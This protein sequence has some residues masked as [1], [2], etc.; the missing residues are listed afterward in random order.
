MQL[1]LPPPENWQDFQRLCRDLWSRIWDDSNAQINGRDGLSQFGV[2]ISGFSA[3]VGFVGVQCK[4]KSLLLRTR[5]SPSELRIEV[6]RAK[7]YTPPLRQ[8]ILATTGPSDPTIQEEARRI[9]AENLRNNLFSVKVWSWTDIVLELQRHHDLLSDYFEA[10]YPKELDSPSRRTATYEAQYRKLLLA[11]VSRVQLFGLDDDPATPRDVDLR[12]AFTQLRVGFGDDGAHKRKRSFSRDEFDPGHSLSFSRM[13]GM[14]PLLG[15]RLLIEGSAGSGKTTLLHWAAAEALFFQI[16][17]GLSPVYLQDEAELTLK[18]F[19]SL[20][21][22]NQ[23]RVEFVDPSAAPG[24]SGIFRR[25]RDLFREDNPNRNSRFLIE[26]NWRRRIPFLVNLRLCTEGRLPKVDELPSHVTREVARAPEHWVAD[27][28]AD[29]RGLLLLDGIDEVPGVSRS[30]MSDSINAYLEAFG[31]STFVV[32]SRPGAVRDTVWDKLFNGMRVSVRP[33]A[34]VDRNLFIERWHAAAAKET[35]ERGRQ[36][37]AGEFLDSA[38]SLKGKIESSPALAQLSENPLLCAGICY[39]HRIRT[40]EIP[41]RI[42]SLY[43]KL[44]DMLIHRRDRERWGEKGSRAFS[45]VNAALDKEEKISILA[46]IANFMVR[47]GVFALDQKRAIRQVD[48]ALRGLRKKSISAIDVLEFL[49]ER[50]VVLSSTDQG[51]IEFINNGLRSYLAAL[52]FEAEGSETQPID[53]AIANSD[54]DLPVLAAAIGG[55]KYRKLIIEA[56]IS[57]S[58]SSS[59]K[60]ERDLNF[61]LVRCAATGLIPDELIDKVNEIEQRIL[62]PRNSEEA[63]AVAELGERIIPCLHPDG[64]MHSDVAAANVRA[65]RLMGTSESLTIVRRYLDWQSLNVVEEIAQAINPLEI[66]LVLKA[67]LVDSDAIE[68]G[69]SIRRHIVDAHLAI[70]SSR[71]STIE[72]LDLSRTGIRSTNSLTVFSRLKK[73]DLSYSMVSDLS[74]LREMNELKELNISGTDI[75]DRHSIVLPKGL[76]RF[77]AGES[78]LPL[79]ALKDI[80]QGRVWE[81]FKPKFELL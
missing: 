67:V 11:H 6:N 4:K 69:A 35:A 17:G 22:L 59:A 30:E 7:E 29:G 3:Q 42:G 78:Q 40:D 77:Y 19:R 8:F 49:E 41:R 46:T 63:A 26:K 55:T 61:M 27:T 64:R 28:L 47:E 32:T 43:K 74:A 54:P 62:P 37:P 65:L 72:E 45:L 5:V 13:L 81:D 60:L 25:A 71:A 2:D 50:S 73:L 23:W 53:R 18:E 76:R 12:T 36:I 52:G 1:Q 33:M 51:E 66:P 21:L 10:L 70:L 20:G 75:S 56:I 57:R 80:Y 15:D 31:K 14:L 58:G 68:I 79:Q 9:T 24:L 34:P 44:C 39:L 48:A 38:Q 16:R